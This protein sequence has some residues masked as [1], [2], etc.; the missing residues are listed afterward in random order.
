MDSERTFKELWRFSISRQK[1]F[2]MKI[3]GAVTPNVA[4][5]AAV[6]VDDNATATAKTAK[7]LIYGGTTIPF[8]SA[9]TTRLYL[10]DLNTGK[11][12]KVKTCKDRGDFD[13]HNITAQEYF[14]ANPPAVAGALGNFVGVLQGMG[15]GHLL[16]QVGLNGGGPNMNPDGGNP[17]NDADGEGDEDHESDWE[18]M[19]SDD[20]EE[21][22]DSDPEEFDENFPVAA[23]GQAIL[24]VPNE[25]D[26]QVLYS[27]GGTNG[28]DFFS[29][30]HRFNFREGTWTKCHVTG[31]NRGPEARYRH[32]L[33]YWQSKIFMLGGGTQMEVFGF[34]SLW[35]FD[36]ARGEG[37]FGQGVWK[38]VP[39]TPDP[40]FPID[41]S[42]E[43]QFPAPR[44]CH[45]CV[46]RGKYVYVFGGFD[47]ARI[48]GDCWQLDLEQ[49]QWK[50]L[51][52]KQPVPSYFSSSAQSS[53]GQVFSFGG[54]IGE[55]AKTR[56]NNLHSMWLGVPKL[57]QIA[58]QSVLHYLPHLADLP[59]EKL[60]Y[61]GVPLDLVKSVVDAA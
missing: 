35:Y 12:T 50:Q 13:P 26:G 2:K 8:G 51:S 52:C 33:A 29:D 19:D 43:E 23:Y 14:G 3:S 46:Q 60:V 32:E 42:L 41:E 37:Q 24:T 54:V 7:M 11:F 40:T 56:T 30:V 5:M 58:W 61:G 39:T 22:Q 59:A 34:T 36:T 45:D 31:F 49:L 6:V 21:E 1:W 25:T 57:R 53:E 9:L 18:D 27:V 28:H 55:D 20:D 16:N 10:V 44:R 48:L 17:A 4:S 38:S 47:G 15:L